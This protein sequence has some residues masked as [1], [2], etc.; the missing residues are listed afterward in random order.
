M[1]KQK[2]VNWGIMGLSRHAENIARAILH[3]KNGRVVAVSSK[4]IAHAREFATRLAGVHFGTHRELLARPDIDAV[5]IASPNHEHPRQVRDAA[6]AKKHVLCEKPFALSLRDGIRA[7]NA[8]KQN[9]IHAAVGFHLRH[10]PAF[11]K[12]RELIRAGKLGK[13]QLIQMHWS[14]GE[15]GQIT[16]PVLPFFMKWREDF[17]KSGGGS[18][19]ARGTHLIDL[20]R[21]LTQK[22]IAAVSALTD[23]EKKRNIDTT[24]LGLLRIGGVFAALI[25][26]RLIPYAMNSIVLYGSRGRLEIL[27]ALNPR[28]TGLL[29]LKTAAAKTYAFK[30]EGDLY[31]KEVEDFGATIL[32]R[33]KGK[34]ATLADGLAITAFTEAFIRSA[35]S[36]KEIP[37]AKIRKLG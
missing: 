24:A 23:G 17:R 9:R 11:Q 19:I 32:N 27:D 3:S 25:T 13:L 1:K 22:E 34:N 10:H 28:S 33:K 15:P 21:F 29:K 7:A 20:V 12:A 2:K 37:I 26:S 16:L 14:V 6:R 36:K 5:F 31:Q 30:K 8:V 18:V 4:N 35:L